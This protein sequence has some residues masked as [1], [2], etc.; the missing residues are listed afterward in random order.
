MYICYYDTQV[1][2]DGF[3]GNKKILLCAMDDALSA[4]QET[5]GLL[6]NTD[7]LAGYLSNGVKLAVAGIPSS[8]MPVITINSYG[9]SSIQFKNC[10]KIY[11]FIRKQVDASPARQLSKKVMKALMEK[12]ISVFGGNERMTSSILTACIQQYAWECTQKLRSAMLLNL[13]LYDSD[14]AGYTKTLLDTIN[15]GV[16]AAFTAQEM[17]DNAT[18]FQKSC[19]DKFYITIPSRE[20]LLET[21]TLRATE[22]REEEEIDV[23]PH[24]LVPSRDTVCIPY[25]KKEYETPMYKEALGVSGLAAP[26]QPKLYSIIGNKENNGL[27]IQENEKEYYSAL[28]RWIKFNIR[29]YYHEELDTIDPLSLSYLEALVSELYIW[30]WKHNPHVPISYEPGQSQSD[31]IESNYKFA[32]YAGFDTQ[33][34]NAVVYLLNFLKVA[35]AEC[36]FEVYPQAVIQLGRWGSRKG[37]AVQ[38]SSYDTVFDLG[39]NRISD[40]AESLADYKKENINGRMCQLVS[41]VYDGTEIAD[42]RIGFSR[43]PMPVGVGLK[44]M[45]TGSGDGIAITVYYSM[46]DAVREIVSGN[47]TVDGIDYSGGRFRTTAVSLDRVDVETVMREVDEPPAGQLKFPVF[48]SQGMIDLY[49]NLNTNHYANQ[50]TQFNLM[51]TKMPYSEIL[52]SIDE[53]SFSTYRELAEIVGTIGNRKRIIDYMIVRDLVRV[54]HEAASKYHDGMGLQE[55]L[56]VWHHAVLDTGYVNESYFYVDRT[57][58]EEPLPGT[59]LENASWCFWHDAAKPDVQKISSFENAGGT[60]TGSAGGP[61]Q[62]SRQQKQDKPVVFIMS[63]PAGSTYCRITHNGE[64]ILLCACYV[65]TLRGKKYNRFIVLG[66]EAGK[67]I[68]PEKITREISVFK[69]VAYM[70]HAIYA[71]TINDSNSNQLLFDSRETVKYARDVLKDLK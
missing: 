10:T 70:A 6:N 18:V 41:L 30:H 35:S 42:K 13:S 52:S 24:S 17:A 16:S 66:K 58:R 19:T 43:W 1:S 20:S 26:Q 27:D 8:K 9:S 3:I 63:P 36:G 62:D 37:T 55:I 4:V 68:P 2:A 47:L 38:F 21:R 45:Y 48:R 56:D 32:A 59:K 11:E 40:K 39:R 51:R 57:N 53:S 25:E 28:V 64:Q 60:K 34:E 49:M 65:Y 22:A 61:A 14:L 29:E 46:I 15:R 67:Q 69:L 12:L 71:V 31:S 33:R 44:E 23:D 7:L 50:E 54:Y 5:T